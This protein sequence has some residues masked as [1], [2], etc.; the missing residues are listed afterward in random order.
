MHT[1][2]DLI[3]FLVFEFLAVYFVSTDTDQLNYYK[4]LLATIIENKLS[5]KK[6]FFLYI[7]YY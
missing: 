4:V 5:L 7:F 6:N 2:D 1:Q 3:N